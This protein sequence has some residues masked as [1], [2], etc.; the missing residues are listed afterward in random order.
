[1]KRV[2]MSNVS[3]RGKR[4]SIKKV[5][6]KELRTELNNPANTNVRQLMTPFFS[7]FFMEGRFPL[8]DTFDILTRFIVGDVMGLVVVLLVLVVILKLVRRIGRV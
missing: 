5:E 8:E 2:R 6:K 1:M 3:S 7:T 4:P